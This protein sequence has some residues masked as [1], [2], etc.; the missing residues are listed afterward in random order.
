MSAARLILALCALGAFAA[1][2]AFAQV[3]D[4]D[5]DGIPDHLERNGFRFDSV[6][7]QPVACTPGVDR[8]CFVTDPL[9]WSSDGDPYSDWQEASGINMDATVEAPYNSPLVAAYP[10]I[11]VVLDQY[12]ITPNGTITDS[13]GGALADGQAYTASVESTRGASVSVSAGVFDGV[14]GGGVE[15]EVSY[16]RTVGY[17]STATWSQEVNWE[18]TESTDIQNAATLSLSLFA[19][20]TGGA[21]AL[22]VRPTFNIYIGSER[23]T[24]VLPDAPFRQSLAPGEAST[25]V[26]PIM[27][28]NPLGVP[29]SLA[30]L[31][32]LQLGAPVTIEVV[33]MLADIQRW[34]PQDSNWGCGSGDSCSWSTFQ[35]Q[36]LPRTLRLLVDFGYS[37]DSAAAVPLRFRG[38]PYEYRV[39]TGSPSAS[40]DLTLRDLLG[41]AGFD[42]GQAGGEVTIEGRPYPSAWTLAEQPDS[43]GFTAIAQAWSDAGEPASLLDVVMPRRATLFMSSP[44]PND[45][46]A[47]IR[48]TR[49]LPG[50]R[51]V[52]AV[53]VPRGGLPIASAAAHVFQNGV[54][55]VVP[56]VQA[57]L[58]AYWTTEGSAVPIDYPVG[59]AS[60]YVTFT[61]VSGTVQ[62][63]EAPIT[64]PITPVASCGDVPKEDLVQVD[65]RNDAGLAILF[66]G[67]NLDR[68]I[69]AY[70]LEGSDV[71]RFWVPQSMPTPTATIFGIAVVDER[72]AVMVT[73]PSGVFRSTDRGRTWLP[74]SE[75]PLSEPLPEPLGRAY[76]IDFNPV[77][78]TLI[79]AGESV[80]PFVLEYGTGRSTDGGLVWDLVPG[81]DQPMTRVVHAGDGVW[82]RWGSTTI[83]AGAL[84]LLRRSTDDGRTWSQVSLPSGLSRIFDIK[85]GDASAGLMTGTGTNGDILLRTTDGGLTWTGILATQPG[86]DRFLS[87]AYAGNGTWYVAEQVNTT[88]DYGRLHR[89][90][91][92]GA[93]GSWQALDVDMPGGFGTF[94]RVLFTSPDVGFVGERSADDLWRTTDGGATWLRE[95]RPFAFPIRALQPIARFDDE[96]IL[97]V[98]G[99]TGIVMTTNGGDGIPPNPDSDGDGVPDAEDAFPNDPTE[100][101]DTDGDG[102]GNNADPDD[103][104]DGISDVDEIRFGLDPLD[105]TDAELDADRDGYSNR[106]EI[107][108]GTDPR[109]PNSNPGERRQKLQT[110]INQLLLD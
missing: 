19:R 60:S 39:Y 100:T 3:V 67:G 14:F 53:A 24:T 40:P 93:P 44:D 17:A 78:G 49:F 58:G 42:L 13:S 27:N 81:E 10:V 16:S 54:E 1:P 48:E 62:R 71:T 33:D 74:L 34:R 22:N 101:V 89:S 79:L 69:E 37:G 31:R 97:A 85:F 87:V 88:N 102:I 50:L 110:L 66:P 45:P 15:G 105:P 7:G 59:A 94:I 30:R 91:S 106:E 8:P 35:N 52:R 84:P 2:G 76:G 4:S 38:N 61:D 23:V 64:L 55:T 32:A 72:T 90:R 43:F 104:G 107:N 86:E 12:S 73:N 108:A 47:A 6:T 28:G 51:G 65:D 20:N 26:V 25:P 41:I 80:D 57:E 98:G 56:M 99:T 82:L 75:F 109:D 92:D 29:L 18:T 5:L 46:G 9:A 103:D 11:E 96:H 83:A 95:P 36:I 68:P 70:C 77:T 21:T 63:S